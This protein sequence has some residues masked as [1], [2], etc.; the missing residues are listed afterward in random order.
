MCK[1]NEEYCR[2]CCKRY[3]LNRGSVTAQC[4]GRILII[5]CFSSNNNNNNNIIIIM[6]GNRG[7]IIKQTVL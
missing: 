6:R 4:T 1:C 2:K 3:G 5:G 7:K